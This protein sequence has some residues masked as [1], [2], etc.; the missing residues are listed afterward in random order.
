MAT[1]YDV[2]ERAG[3]SVGTVSRFLNDSGYVSKSARERIQEAIFSVG[4]V[5]NSAARSLTTKRTGLIGFV[6]SDLV[7][8]FSAEL[9]HG[10]ADRAAQR[11][12]CVLNAV[13]EGS[14]QR[15]LQTLRVLRE[16]SV[17]GLIVAPPETPRVKRELGALAESGLPMVLLGMRLRP[18]TTDR[19]ATSTYE[20]ARAAVE[21]LVGL[22]H[23]RIALITGN[24]RRKI[25]VDRYRG[26]YDALAAAGLPYDE[27]L[28]VEVALNRTGGAAALA[29]LVGRRNR[30]TAVFTVNDAT[31]LGAMQEAA[32]RGIRVPA[33]LSVVGF[34][35]VDLAAHGVP[36]LTT[37]AQP[38]REMGALAIDLLTERMAGTAPAWPVEHRLDCTLMVRASTA[39]PKRRQ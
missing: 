26:Y 36:P 25:A 2:A 33:D 19:I 6:T 24:R 18:D 35:D 31:A 12:F 10:I 11:G 34:D 16:H 9:A 37:V 23:R 14:E 29:G 8:P 20:G 4:Y 32:R 7:N 17:D 5:P 1:V 30:P 27:R 28:V 22:G 13:T 39:P 38:K 21:H 3:L 15:I